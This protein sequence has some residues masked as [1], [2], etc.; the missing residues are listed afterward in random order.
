MTG[1][2]DERTKKARAADLL[3][4]ATASKE[5]FARASVGTTTRVLLEQRL[6]DGRWVGHADDHVLVAVAP[7]PGDDLDQENAVATVR[8]LA[9]D[10]AVP[11]RVTGDILSLDPA[12]RPLR[13]AIRVLGLAKGGTHD[14]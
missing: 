5:R 7:R 12:P 14:R 11:D 10:P 1:Q 3:A 9:V 8:R 13:R 4:L 6:D 2:V